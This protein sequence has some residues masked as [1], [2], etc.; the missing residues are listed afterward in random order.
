[1]SLW[2]TR[3]R[4]GVHIVRLIYIYIRTYGSTLCLWK[5][6]LAPSGLAKNMLQQFFYFL[7]QFSIFYNNFLFP[8]TNKKN[9]V[10]FSLRDD[11]EVKMTFYSWRMPQKEVQTMATIGNDNDVSFAK[12]VGITTTYDSS[13]RRL[14]ESSIWH[15]QV[16]AGVARC[17]QHHC[18][19][20]SSASGLIRRWH[21]LAE[22][23]WTI[24]FS[25]SSPPS[26]F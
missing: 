24:E 12:R 20:S 7:Q 4:R 8:T 22:L 21:V 16:V 1:M 17:P 5:K 15:R 25:S 2:K 26:C 14:F 6:E 23:H 19:R 11:C 10:A 13:E 18:I 9:V 3:Y